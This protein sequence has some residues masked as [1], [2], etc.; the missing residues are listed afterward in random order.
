MVCVFAYSF[1]QVFGF[2]CCTLRSFNEG[3]FLI[4]IGLAPAIVATQAEHVYTTIFN[5]FFF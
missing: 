2:A 1:L 5:T 4:N 3:G